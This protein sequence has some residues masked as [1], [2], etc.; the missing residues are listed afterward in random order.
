M[1]TYDPDTLR[2]LAGDIELELTNRGERRAVITD[3]TAKYLQEFLAFRHVVRNIYG[4]ELDVER[5]ALLVEKYP[6]AWSRFEQDT[7]DFIEWLRALAIG[8]DEAL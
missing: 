8:L 7:K 4:F 1:R 5:M 6:L 3:E 2:E